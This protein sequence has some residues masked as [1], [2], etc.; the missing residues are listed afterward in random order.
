MQKLTGGSGEAFDLGAATL[1]EEA[2]DPVTGLSHATLRADIFE[3]LYKTEIGWVLHR[4][5]RTDPSAESWE[6]IEEPEVAAWLARN[7]HALPPEL[8]SE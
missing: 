1:Y 3:E 4:S 8:K 6:K 2:R 7:G 5:D